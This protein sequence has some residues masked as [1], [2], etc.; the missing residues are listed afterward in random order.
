MI[1]VSNDKKSKMLQKNSSRHTQ[2]STVIYFNLT[3][4]NF[5]ICAL[6]FH[7]GLFHFFQCPFRG[8]F[9]VYLTKHRA[10]IKKIFKCLKYVSYDYVG[11][12]KRQKLKGKQSR[13]AYEGKK[14]ASNS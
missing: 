2:L 1:G 8:R 9:N 6:M 3:R 11:K 13:K 4:K 7:F 14:G 5:V 12:Q 10:N